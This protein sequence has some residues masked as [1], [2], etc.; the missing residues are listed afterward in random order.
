MIIVN[1]NLA[2]NTIKVLPRYYSTVT[3]NI[4]VTITNEDTRQ[5]VSHVVS[6]VTVSDGFLS[7]KTSAS[8]TENSTYRVKIVD[9]TIERVVFRGKIFSTDQ[10]KQNYIING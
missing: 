5:D 7:F 1:V 6:S 4:T 9:K 8:F 10:S 2:T 3:T